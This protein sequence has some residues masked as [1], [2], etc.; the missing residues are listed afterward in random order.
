[1]KISRVTCCLFILLLS[2]VAFAFT[3]NVPRAHAASG[4]T[5]VIKG[6][7]LHADRASTTSM[8]ISKPLYTLTPFKTESI[9]KPLTLLTSL[10]ARLTLRTNET[11]MYASGG[12][13]NPTFKIDK[14]L[15][16]AS[17]SATIPVTAHPV[18]SM[19]NDFQE[20]IRSGQVPRTRWASRSRCLYPIVPTAQDRSVVERAD[21]DIGF[22]AEPGPGQFLGEPPDLAPSGDRCLAVEVHRM[23]EDGILAKEADRDDLPRFGIVAEAGGIWHADELVVDDR[24]D[25]LERFRHHCAGPRCPSRR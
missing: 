18:R 13:D 11:L 16:S 14:D 6:H 2:L 10:S 7:G 23:N 3:T 5:I 12:T 4:N 1:M 20:V 24:S 19:G 25:D 15:L 8:A 17:L 9:I 22:A 21:Q